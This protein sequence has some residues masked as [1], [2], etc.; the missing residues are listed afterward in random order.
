MANIDN[1]CSNMHIKNYNLLSDIRGYKPFKKNNNLSKIDDVIQDLSAQITAFTNIET[2]R[3]PKYAECLQTVNKSLLTV[4]HHF[5]QIRNKEKGVAVR[6]FCKVFPKS[7][8]ARKIKIKDNASRALIEQLLHTSAGQI[9]KHKWQHAKKQIVK[10][11]YPTDSYTLALINKKGFAQQAAEEIKNWLYSKGSFTHKGALI[12]KSVSEMLERH[13]S[14]NKIV[15]AEICNDFMLAMLISAAPYL[16]HDDLATLK[17]E[18]ESWSKQAEAVDSKK[19]NADE[20]ASW[21]I[22]ANYIYRLW[23]QVQTADHLA[24]QFDKQYV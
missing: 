3:H 1:L 20:K 17:S 14:N 9:T 18:S 8:Y 22:N 21:F 23:Q 15:G 4:K 12:Y 13:E 11:Q 10:M 16:S 5:T 24:A 19:M 6:L 2:S 7:A